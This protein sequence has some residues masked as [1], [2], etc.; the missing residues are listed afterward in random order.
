M[1]T[2][3]AR[4]TTKPRRQKESSQKEPSLSVPR[5]TSSCAPPLLERRPK[6]AQQGPVPFTFGRREDALPTLEDRG[7][8]NLV[9]LAVIARLGEHDPDLLACRFHRFR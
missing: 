8:S 4:K 9:L 2:R 6:G 3:A 5:R 7:S 1:E